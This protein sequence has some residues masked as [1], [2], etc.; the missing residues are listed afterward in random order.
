M[1]TPE[2]VNEST[3]AIDAIEAIEARVVALEHSAAR[4][5]LVR[6]VEHLATCI[7]A[8]DF[9]GLTAPAYEAMLTAWRLGADGGPIRFEAGDVFTWIVSP[10]DFGADVRLV[11]T[12]WA[13]DVVLRVAPPV[14]EIARAGRTLRLWTAWAETAEQ[15]RDLGDT[16]P[17][18]RDVGLAITWDIARTMHGT[19]LD[20][21]RSHSPDF[22]SVR[23]G[24]R[25]YSFTPTQ[26][27]VIDV[28]WRAWES[29]SPDVGG[30]TLL[31]VADCAD[32]RLVDIFRRCPA[33]GV[34]IVDGAT[35]GAKRLA[36]PPNS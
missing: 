34:L 21:R 18:R 7:E 24:G 11:V 27:A 22:R 14:D 20:L 8:G 25:A 15:F 30:E 4:Q 35:K 3:P 12:G 9:C 2:L 10:P 29:G 1:S 23:W 28:L 36:D 32:S 31:E 33:W 17:N 6:L 26:A 16:L 13:G 5:R 19:D